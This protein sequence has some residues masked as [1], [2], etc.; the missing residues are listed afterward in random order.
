[1]I[2]TKLPGGNEAST[3]GVSATSFDGSTPTGHTHPLS[4]RDVSAYACAHGAGR[5]RQ[6]AQKSRGAG[7]SCDRDLQDI[8]CAALQDRILAVV[9]PG[10]SVRDSRPGV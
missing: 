7:P 2:G 8:P 1:M 3:S 9:R 4:A 10:V 6:R 5:L